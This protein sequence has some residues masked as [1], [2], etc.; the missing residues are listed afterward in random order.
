[1]VI[2]T[3][4]IIELKYGEELDYILWEL[5]RGGLPL[6]LQIQAIGP[7]VLLAIKLWIDVGTLG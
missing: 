2:E 1:M 7:P 5:A 3:L 4:I 6:V